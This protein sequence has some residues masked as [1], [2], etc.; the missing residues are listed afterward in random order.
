TRGFF[1]GGKAATADWSAADTFTMHSS[2]AGALGITAGGGRTVAT[3]TFFGVGG[4]WHV[5]ALRWSTVLGSNI[6]SLFTG[7]TRYSARYTSTG[8]LTFTQL[9]I[10]NRYAAGLTAGDFLGGEMRGFAFWQS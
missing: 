9:G 4:L 8:N 6:V 5:G 10:M 2:G 7:G 3:S 1:T